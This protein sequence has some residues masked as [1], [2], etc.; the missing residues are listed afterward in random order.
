[1]KKVCKKY[2]HM[3]RSDALYTEMNYVIENFSEHLI[4]VMTLC[5][6]SAQEAGNN[7]DALTDLYTVL[8][9]I[10]HIIESILAQE[11]L[12]DF[13]EEQIPTII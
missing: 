4:R 3:Q 10:F 13:Y 11:E 5:I 8:N 12:P 9:A 2:R 7:F 6:N 1:M